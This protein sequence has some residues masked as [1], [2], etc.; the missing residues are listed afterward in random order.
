M[1]TEDATRWAAYVV[2]MERGRGRGK[3]GG[4]ERRRETE[5]KVGEYSKGQ[6]RD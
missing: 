4:R 6:I 3:E 5:R 2:N 1:K